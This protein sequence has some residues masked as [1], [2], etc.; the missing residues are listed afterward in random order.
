MFHIST[1]IECRQVEDNFL[2]H[3]SYFCGHEYKI[4]FYSKLYISPHP[5][6][7]IFFRNQVL[8]KIK[9]YLFQSHVA[10]SLHDNSRLQSGSYKSWEKL[11]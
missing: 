11:L 8:E 9:T 4:F 2:I 10:H 5:K 6:I 7:A 3:S 1:W